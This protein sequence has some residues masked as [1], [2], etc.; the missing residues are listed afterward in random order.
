MISVDLIDVVNPRVRNRKI[1]REITAS[2]AE[3]GLKKRITV[4]RRAHL[5]GT[6]YS[7]VCGQARAHL[8]KAIDVATQQEAGLFRLRA[9]HAL[10]ELLVRNG[11]AKEAHDILAP[12]Y[13][14]LTE[15][16]GAP[17]LTNAKALLDSLEA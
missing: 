6:R 5:D 7:L 14:S 2:I 15:G 11:K 8:Q 3:L 1:F 10:A 12:A 17:V 4:T 16:V 9:S 13:G